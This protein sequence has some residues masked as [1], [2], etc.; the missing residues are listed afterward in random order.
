[1]SK[2]EYV[3]VGSQGLVNANT[4]TATAIPTGADGVLVQ[5]LEDATGCFSFNNAS[6][7]TSTGFILK[8]YDLYEFPLDSSQKGYI[9]T[10]TAAANKLVYQFIKYINR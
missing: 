8:Q 10:K 7:S 2:K 3:Y 1:M 4:A 5:S 6:V 9:Y